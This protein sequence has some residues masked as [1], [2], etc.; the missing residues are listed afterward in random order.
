MTAFRGLFIQC[1]NWI[2]GGYLACSTSLLKQWGERENWHS[3]SA[4]TRSPICSDVH[5]GSDRVQVLRRG[6]IK[7]QKK[8]NWVCLHFAPA[9]GIG[10][11]ESSPSTVH[12]DV[13]LQTL[14]HRPSGNIC[15]PRVQLSSG[16]VSVIFNIRPFWKDRTEAEHSGKHLNGI[17][18]LIYS[19]RLAQL[20]SH[21]NLW[22]TLW[23][24]DR[25]TFTWHRPGSKTDRL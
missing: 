6:G 24:N 10:L 5:P 18:M 23:M 9:S 1:I 12:G 11:C 13:P 21:F 16:H 3:R 7:E 4:V 25:A 15:S 22:L 20:F 17:I 2:I 8:T 19:G 14:Q